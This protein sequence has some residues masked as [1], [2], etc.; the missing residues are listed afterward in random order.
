[1][2]LTTYTEAF[3]ELNVRI[4]DK[5]TDFLKGLEREGY[6]EKAICYAIAKSENKIM[7]FRGDTRF[8]SVIA[9]EVRKNVWTK[10]DPRWKEYNARKVR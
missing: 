10:Q 8:L 3:D 7:Q 9:N 4:T 2:K 1:M 5:I 6:T